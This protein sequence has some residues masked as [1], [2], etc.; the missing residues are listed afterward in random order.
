MMSLLKHSALFLRSLIFLLGLLLFLDGTI[1]IFNGKIHLGILLPI[2]I[3][4]GLCCYAL[5]DHKIQF[6]LQQHPNAQKCYRYGKYAFLFWLISVFIFFIYLAKNIQHTQPTEKIQAMLVLGS[7]IIK[8]QPTAALAARLDQAAQ[9]HQ[10]FPQA[11]IIVTGGVG[12]GKKYS[13]AEVMSNYLQQHHHIATAQIALENQSTST[14]LNLKN[15]QSILKQHHL[16]PSSSIAIVTSDF[17]TLR[18]AAIARKQGYQDITVVS[19]T[20]PLSIRYNAWLREYFA[21]LSGWILNEY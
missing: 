15:S 13:E 16:S 8:D 19:A 17:H 18:A 1:L 14:E 11:L 2:L 10:T 6:K 3:G 7:G 5:Y 12:Y 20:T 4:A 21:Y 9:L